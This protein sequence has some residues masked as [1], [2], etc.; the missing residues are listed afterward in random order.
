[1]G[2]NADVPSVVR[3]YVL[4]NGQAQS[5]SARRPRTRGVYPVEPFKDSSL[6][7]LGHANSLV[8]DRYL[9]QFPASPYP[10]AHRGVLTGV[11][12]S[13]VYEVADRGN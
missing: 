11:G 7:L 1:M 5:G 8:H 13:V 3:R 10:N 4:H 2:P 12:D 6:L 9:N